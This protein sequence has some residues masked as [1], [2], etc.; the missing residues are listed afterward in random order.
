MPA[1]QSHKKK[2]D[3]SSIKVTV[4]PEG[5]PNPGN[6]YSMLSPEARLKQLQ[7]LYQQIYLRVIEGNTKD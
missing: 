6:P 3:W 7:A 2:V 5:E 1:K 4:V